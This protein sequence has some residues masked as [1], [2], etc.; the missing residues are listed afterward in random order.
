MKTITYYTVIIGQRGCFVKYA[1]PPQYAT[2]LFPGAFEGP[3]EASQEF[4]VATRGDVAYLPEKA[5]ER[6]VDELASHYKQDQV[7]LTEW[8]Q[9]KPIRI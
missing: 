1:T 4:K 6:K 9:G 5:F 8:L 2:Q 3:G 7:K